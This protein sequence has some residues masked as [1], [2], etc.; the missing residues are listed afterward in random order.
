MVLFRYRLLGR[1]T[2]MPGGLHARLCHAFLVLMKF[3]GLDECS[4][5]ENTVNGYRRRTYGHV[6]ISWSVGRPCGCLVGG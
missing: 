1:D 3:S 5:I 2:A 4:I 6:I